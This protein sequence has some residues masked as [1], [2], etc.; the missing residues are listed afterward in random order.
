MNYLPVIPVSVA[1]AA[2][3]IA[4]FTDLRRFQIY[5]WIT[6]PLFASGLLYHG[7]VDGQGEFASSM[8]GAM[9]GFG[10]LFIFYLLG[11]MGSGDVKLMAGIG[12]W[13]GLDLTLDVI[14]ATAVAGAIYALVL[15]LAFSPLRET[16]INFQI[17]Y[18][19]LAAIGRSLAA[20]DQV[21][22]V[23]NRPNH[24]QRLIPFA[25]MIMVGLLSILMMRAMR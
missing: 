21:E 9:L 8:L 25:A 7:M 1:L 3:A 15:M 14:V 18:F 13:L 10:F 23:V 24:R 6:F 17:M 11:G 12:A 5:N 2:V 19:R 16:V 22:A 4:V 20:E